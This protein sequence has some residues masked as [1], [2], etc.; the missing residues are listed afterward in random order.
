MDGLPDCNQP[1]GASNYTQVIDN[2]SF[3]HLNYPV[4]CLKKKGVLHRGVCFQSSKSY[5]WCPRL[6]RPGVSLCR[7][8]GQTSLPTQHFPGS[9]PA[10]PTLPPPPRVW[11]TLVI[12]S[13][14]NG[15]QLYS[16]RFH[17]YTR[18]RESHVI[19]GRAALSH[20]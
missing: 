19:S 9:S 14:P 2:W 13:T 10:A 6:D 11:C 12:P 3:P 1:R 5:D 17:M 20:E 16:L 18:C 7:G 4:H 15:I 8:R